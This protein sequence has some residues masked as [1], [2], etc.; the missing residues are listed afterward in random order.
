M[1]KLLEN[2]EF[3]IL[4]IAAS[5]GL[6]LKYIGIIPEEQLFSVTLILIILLS[7]FELSKSNKIEAQLQEISCKVNNVNDKNIRIG[8]IGDRWYWHD[9]GPLTIGN[10]RNVALRTKTIQTLLDHFKNSPDYHDNLRAASKDVGITFG[11]DIKRELI[12]KKLYPY[13]DLNKR[14]K[15]WEEYDSDTG[16]GKF[17]LSEIN[18]RNNHISGQ[19]R[20]KNAFTSADRINGQNSCLFFEGYLEGV[21]KEFVGVEVDVKEISCGF[22]TNSDSCIFSVNSRTNS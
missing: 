14:I 6:L 17:S 21:F 22:I 15:R 12:E 9:D 8:R 16:M 20:I 1:N 2:I 4:V 18:V 11:E 3:K 19:L 5:I 13:S 10:T 7:L